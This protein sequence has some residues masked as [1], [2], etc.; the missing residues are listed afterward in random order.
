MRHFKE[1]TI[2]IVGNAETLW[3]KFGEAGAENN[4][5]HGVGSTMFCSARGGWGDLVMD[6][7]NMKCKAVQ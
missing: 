1:C 6:V 4:D 2:R 5:C 7:Q 3:V